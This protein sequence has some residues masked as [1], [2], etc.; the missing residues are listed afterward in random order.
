[1][2]VSTIGNT[3]SY[4]DA[5]FTYDYSV[6]ANGTVGISNTDLGMTTPA[7]HFFGTFMN[8]STGNADVVLRNISASYIGLRNLTSAVKTGT[9]TVGVRYIKRNV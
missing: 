6:P 5:S 4:T 3:L 2:A 8:L 7:G 1:M 9:L